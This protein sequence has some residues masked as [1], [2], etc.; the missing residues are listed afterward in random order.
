M[1]RNRVLQ[2]VDRERDRQERLRREGRFNNTCAA[3]DMSDADKLAVLGEEY[4]EVCRAL[5]ERNR[6]VSDF[7]NTDLA[8]ELIHLAAVSVAWLERLTELNEV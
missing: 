3:H 7:H 4:G 6:A 5:L 8:R 1:V 2:M